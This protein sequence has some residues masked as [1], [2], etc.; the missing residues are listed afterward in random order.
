MLD[1]LPGFLRNQA[2]YRDLILTLRE[3]GLN[4]GIQFLVTMWSGSA[5]I[6]GGGADV[7]FQ[8]HC[9]LHRLQ[10]FRL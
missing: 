2:A 7:L 4:T 9:R 10:H 8:H 6:V 3:L 1:P 5:G